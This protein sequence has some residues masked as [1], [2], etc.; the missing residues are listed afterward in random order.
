MILDNEGQRELM[1]A[2][3]K[4]TVFRGDMLEAIFRLKLSIEQATIGGV[5]CECAD[6]QKE[7]VKG[8][9]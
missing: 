4:Q 3:L 7:N 5:P 8:V 2:I 1:L 9:N 6:V